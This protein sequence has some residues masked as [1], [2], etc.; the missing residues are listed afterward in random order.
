MI[1][2]EEE[3]GVLVEAGERTAYKIGH[4]RPNLEGQSK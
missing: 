1:T 2:Q 3:E 4:W